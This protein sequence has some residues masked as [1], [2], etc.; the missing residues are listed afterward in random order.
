MRLVNLETGDV[1]AE[2]VMEA[3]TFMKRLKGLLFSEPL[4]KGACLHI[5]P[6]RSIH[7]YWMN[8][9][10]DVL[11]LDDKLQVTGIETEVEPGRIGRTFSRTASV[12]EFPAGSL[13]P[14]RLRLGQAV[15]FVKA[16]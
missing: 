8:Y 10:I 12:V 3:K 7:T 5:E 13:D 15:A 4:P 6:C 14:V 16:Q 1:L 2:R 11:H 9:A